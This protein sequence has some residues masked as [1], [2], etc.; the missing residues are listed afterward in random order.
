VPLIWLV[1]VTFTGGWQKLFSDSPAIGFLA[2]AN[3][4]EAAIAS[5]AVAADKIDVT[6]TL[7]FNAR[8]DAFVCGL[9]L[10][11]VATIL[12]DSIRV[13]TGILRGTREA[14]VEE[15]PFVLTHLRPEEI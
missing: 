14:K 15:A 8:L 4:L 13:W 7:I 5:G 1:L 3:R 11:L 2:Q 9:F 6:R 10:I 12:I